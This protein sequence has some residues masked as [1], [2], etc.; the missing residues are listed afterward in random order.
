MSPSLPRQAHRL[1]TFGDV[2]LYQRDIALTM[3]RTLTLLMLANGAPVIAKRIFGQRFNWPLDAGMIFIDGRP[4]FGPSKTWRGIIAAVL[5]TTCGATVIGLRPRIG[6]TVALAAT[7]GDLFS[8]FIKRRWAMP[9]SSRAL[10]L[11]QIPESLSPLLVCRQSL[12]LAPLILP[13]VRVCFS[14]ARLAFR[15]CSI[16]HT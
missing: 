4:L 16:R 9:S 12:S 7:A 8:S 6:A 15:C 1:P 5:V 14:S 3:L 13:A 11:D 10:G 2:S